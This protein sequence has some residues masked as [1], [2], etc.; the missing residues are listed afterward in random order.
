MIPSTTQI[1]TG[2]AVIVKA[3]NLLIYAKCSCSGSRPIEHTARYINNHKD[4]FDLPSES[5]LP[6]PELLTA[7]PAR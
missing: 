3:S 6:M 5:T 1:R 2:Q 7:P 4:L